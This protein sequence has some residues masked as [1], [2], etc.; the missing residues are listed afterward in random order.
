MLAQFTDDLRSFSVRAGTVRE[1]LDGAVEAYPMLRIHLQD[2]AGVQRPHVN[3]Y[4]ND[5]ELR[6]L[7][8]LDVAVRDGDQIT[9][10]QSVSGG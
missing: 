6:Q 8:S 1:A 3:V 7:G 5:T 10:I 4:Y 9:I 2:E